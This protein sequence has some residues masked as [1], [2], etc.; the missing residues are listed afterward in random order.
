MQ[1]ISV[2]VPIYNI[3][4]Y[5]RRCLDS[6]INQT[7]K[8]LEIILIDDGSID[9]SGKICDEYAIKDSRIKVVH[10]SNKGVSSA[11]NTGL[12][13]AKGFYISF[14]DGDDWI[15]PKM[16][17]ILYKNAI[18]YNSDISCCGLAQIQKNGEMTTLADNLLKI[19]SKDEL[20]S[21]FFYDPIIK[22]TMYGPCNK[23]IKKEILN[24]IRFDERFAIG[25]D[26]L[27][28]FECLMQVNSVILDNQPLYHYIKRENSATT[29]AFSEKRIHYINVADIL[30]Q[31]CKEKFIYAYPY[32]LI[33]NYTHKLI[34]L[35]KFNKYKSFKKSHNKTYNEYLNFIKLNKKNVWK[36]LPNKR[37]IDYYLILFVPWIYKIL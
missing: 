6:I 25:E 29:A 2:I 24:N 3:D 26:L 8:N 33:W 23:I 34:I 28:L 19:Y 10:E 31:Y 37:K 17:E 22:E 21:G 1:L 35:R 11:R 20:I 7:Y 13:L 36:N 12:N 32:A 18:E 5:L 27:F 4:S 9:T 16:Y 14:V 30:Y 15:S